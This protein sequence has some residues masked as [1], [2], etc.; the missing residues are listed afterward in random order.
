MLFRSVDAFEY[1]W[2]F[3]NDGFSNGT[4]AGNT[5]YTYG[6]GGVY[7]A[8]LEV[9][10]ECGS[11][12]AQQI[13]EIEGATGTND[14]IKFNIKAYPNPVA[15]NLILENVSNDVL[16]FYNT[17]GELVFERKLND[18][19]KHVIDLSELPKGVYIAVLD[20]FKETRIKIT[21]Q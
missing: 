1:V 13:V 7:T 19:N 12:E 17:L 8:V 16:K 4:S 21:K 6:A 2:D 5:I 11:D 20:N 15:S 10:N 3:D 14:D 9:S 18:Q